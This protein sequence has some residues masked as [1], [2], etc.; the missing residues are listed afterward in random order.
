VGVIAMMLVGLPFVVAQVTDTTYVTDHGTIRLVKEIPISRGITIVGD[1]R[2]SQEMFVIQLARFEGMD[3]IPPFLPKGTMLWINPDQV[4]EKFLITGFY[5]SYQEAE[6]A[7]YSWKQF[8][9]FQLAFVR[10]MPFLIRY[11]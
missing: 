6:L 11:E 7:L 8:P 5:G 1:G 9:E 3:S 4:N 2:P 10:S